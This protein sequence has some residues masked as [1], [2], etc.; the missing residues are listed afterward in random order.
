MESEGLQVSGLDVRI[1]DLLDAVRC[2]LADIEPEESE[3]HLDDAASDISTT[4]GVDHF[5]VIS[6]AVDAYML[7]KVL[8]V[9]SRSGGSLADLIDRGLA[10]EFDD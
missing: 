9:L 2:F 1:S 5:D 10:G 7:G 6:M 4:T 3:W 8:D